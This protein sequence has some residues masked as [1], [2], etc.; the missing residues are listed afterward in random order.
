MRG[1]LR[2]TY[3]E[4]IDRRVFIV[5]ILITILVALV[6]FMID[7]SS[8]QVTIN[9]AS[10]VGFNLIA[11]TV[12]RFVELLVFL[13]VMASAGL[14]PSMLVKGRIDFYLSRPVSR[15]F[16]YLSRL[17][18]IWLIYGGLF[19]VCSG[20]I[21]LVAWLRT[22][23][24]DASIIYLPLIHLIGL[25]IWFSIT[26]CAGVMT[27]STP[28]VIMAAFMI[29]V[30]QYIL[31]FHQEAIQLFQ[32]EMANMIVTSLY[33]IIPKT[34]EISSLASDLAAG[35][36]ADWTPLWSSLIVAGLIILTGLGLFKKKSF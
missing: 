10:E 32:S 11:A 17:F 14:V 12:S 9:G 36:P 3:L 35:H 7:F 20:I 21:I 6:I 13:T 2:D 34:G 22:G 31:S 4:L 26:C 18:S 30:A 33:H 5:Y 24:L 8:F 28:M 15:S 25:L 19:L 27:G 23:M 1:I 29:W 16:L